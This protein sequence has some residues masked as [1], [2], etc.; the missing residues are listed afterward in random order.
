MNALAEQQAY[1]QQSAQRFVRYFLMQASEWGAKTR[2]LD[3]P[4][5]LAI[6]QEAFPNIQ[7]AL[8]R[9]LGYL[10]A[11]SLNDGLWYLWR[12]T[13]LRVFDFYDYRGLWVEMYDLLSQGVRWAQHYND[14]RTKAIFLFYQARLDSQ[15]G[16]SEQALAK[17]KKSLQLLTVL[18]EEGWK[19]NLLHF[20]GMLLRK[21]DPQAARQSFELALELWERLNESGGRAATLYEIGRLEEEKADATMAERLYREALTIFQ[22]LGMPRERATLLF[23]LGVLQTDT[24]LLETAL[25]IYKGLLDERGYAQTLHQLGK[26]WHKR[27]NNAQ[28]RALYQEAIQ[29]FDRLGARHSIQSVE[30]DWL[31]LNN[32]NAC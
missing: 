21:Q 9:T 6:L 3:A 19:A 4:A 29:I 32:E 23:Q 31:E 26:A 22:E 14:T 16:R 27:G 7:S 30:R 12:D 5:Y 15:Q 1:F 10:E 2:G 11:G 13:V 28:A 25:Q 17:S 8:V 18:R 20:R 24:E